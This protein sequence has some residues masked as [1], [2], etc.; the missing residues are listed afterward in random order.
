MVSRII[1]CFRFTSRSDLHQQ[2]Q[3][4][5]TL[6]ALDLLE[7]RLDYLPSTEL[8]PD[9]L[10]D[11]QNYTEKPIIL[12]LGD[13]Y[14]D[15]LHPQALE[16]KRALVRNAA[17]TQI[18]LI[19]I[20]LAFFS[21]YADVLS[22][23][24]NTTSSVGT[25]SSRIILSQHTSFAEFM[26]QS[27]ILPETISPDRADYAY[28]FVVPLSTSDQASQFE[29][30]QFDVWATS[31]GSPLS[32]F[33]MGDCCMQTRIF[34]HLFGNQ[35][36]Y[37]AIDAEHLTAPGQPTLA[38]FLT[39]L[40]IFQ[41]MM[42]GHMYT[43][44]AFGTSHGYEIGCI[45]QGFPRNTPIDLTHLQSMVEARRPGY[46]ALSSARREPDEFH[47]TNGVQVG[48]SSSTL[49][50]GDPIRITIRNKDVHPSDYRKFA[51]I[52]R[53][54]H[55]DYPAHL[56]FGDAVELSGSGVFSGRLSAAYVLGG[57]LALQYLTTQH[58]RI[59]AY[60][61]QIGSVSWNDPGWQFDQLQAG[62]DRSYMKCPDP[63]VAEQMET[64]IQDARTERDSI[65][66]QIA[67]LIEN[68]PPG[69]GNPWFGSLRSRLAASL[70]GIPGTRGIEFGS[71]FQAARM[72]GSVHN[73]PYFLDHGKITTRSN[74]A[75]GI[76]GGIS[77]G[78]P[79]RMQIAIKPPASIGQPQQTLNLATQQLDSLVIPGRHD[80]CLIPRILP[81][82]ESICAIILMDKL[83]LQTQRSKSIDFL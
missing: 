77:L 81:V 41:S 65:G 51:T 63:N 11:I 53:P 2:L 42:I 36:T 22:D 57:S 80:P 72:R 62:C 18:T 55:V 3:A 34:G 13:R 64:E 45:I 8:S 5:N 6:S 67:I 37:V 25:S 19:D 1:G 76:I 14:G 60:T 15:A 9:L 39:H 27:P 54:S 74:H 66:G 21:H 69:I 52:P 68:V 29:K 48:E 38:Q 83:L 35:F 28:K 7:I 56:R 43:V 40:D 44:H 75:G 79:I 47:I 12:T 4:A 32:L 26:S 71:G 70:M 16:R 82:V 10:A 31:P 78:T 61:I 20:D 50:T 58:I 24:I 73:D 23:F 17:Q 59:L 30:K 49:S 33:G 46:D